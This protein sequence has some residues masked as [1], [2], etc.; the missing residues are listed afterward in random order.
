LELNTP[1]NN[2]TYEADK[3]VYHLPVFQPGSTI[4]IAPGHRL[5]LSNAEAAYALGGDTRR[6][7]GHGPQG[8]AAR[9]RAPPRPH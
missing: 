5:R 7:P 8:R 9:P 1:V 3:G 6:R 4:A 2:A